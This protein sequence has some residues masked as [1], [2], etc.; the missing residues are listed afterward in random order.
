MRKNVKSNLGSAIAGVGVHRAL[1]RP[2][3][4]VFLFHRVDDR[5]ADDPISVS[6]AAF[7]MWLDAIGDFFEVLPYSE[8]VRRLADGK[9]VSTCASITFDDGYRDNALNAA[10]A[11]QKRGLPATFFI[12]SNLIESE[13]VPFWDESLSFRPEWMS[14]DEV[15]A[16]A[17]AGFEIGNH[18]MDHP[19]LGEID[20]SETERQVSGAQARLTAELGV[21]PIHFSYPFGGR[22]N[23]SAENHDVIKRQ[24]FASCAAAFGGLVRPGDDLQFIR[25]TPICQWHEKPGQLLFE[26]VQERV[27]GNHRA[28]A[29]A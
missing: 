13:T 28:P 7:D 29:H 1:M 22:A 15:R 6:C 26:L 17:S 25:R 16:L 4:V 23:L 5:L 14:W 11:L 9:D 8:M 27:V 20:P 19:N 24:N 3:G 18:T 2:A 10:P 12:A 21:A